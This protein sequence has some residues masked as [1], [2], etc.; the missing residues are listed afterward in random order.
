M[1]DKIIS[2]IKDA[3]YGIAVLFAVLLLI[4]LSG[5][6]FNI[7]VTNVNL[8]AN[9]IFTSLTLKGVHSVGSVIRKKLGK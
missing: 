9:L 5:K 4:V 8:M 6:M 3:A 7:A 2:G 1:K